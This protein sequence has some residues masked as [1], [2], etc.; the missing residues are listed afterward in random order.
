MVYSW[1][2]S[3]I[4]LDSRESGLDLSENG[5]LF[6]RIFRISRIFPP[7]FGRFRRFPRIDLDSRGG[8]VPILENRTL[9]SKIPKNR[10]RFSGRSSP[11]S[12]ES[13]LF[14]KNRSL[15]LRIGSDSQILR[16]SNPILEN[17][18]RFSRIGNGP[19][20]ESRSI[21]GNLR[22]LPNLG[23]KI[24]KIRKILENR[25]PFSEIE[26]QSRF[27]RI[28]PYSRRFPRI[29]FDSRRGLVPIL[30]NRALF[31]QIPKNRPRFSGRRSGP[32]SRE[33]EPILEDSEE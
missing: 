27:S 4:G 31:S 15:F 20:R 32:H 13:N 14:S 11:D 6:S 8:P 10:L 17:R 7:R 16:E 12:R 23:G 21:L 25:P 33:S 24:R 30:E 28:E 9:F 19:P 26:V 22:N 5:G 29:D 18:L 2:S 3:R 1:E